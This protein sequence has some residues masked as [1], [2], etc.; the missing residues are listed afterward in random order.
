MCIGI[1]KYTY[2]CIVSVKAHVQITSVSI[3]I[4]RILY[5]ICFGVLDRVFAASCVVLLVTVY[6]FPSVLKL[7]F[8]MCSRIS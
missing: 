4:F 1:G 2:I 8:I 3:S 7:L 6:L 5:L